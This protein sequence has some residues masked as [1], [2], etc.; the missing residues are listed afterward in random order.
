MFQRFMLMLLFKQII[1][2]EPLRH[3]LKIICKFC[4]MIFDTNKIALPYK[5]VDFTL[6]ILSLL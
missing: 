1:L 2:H 5:R 3:L 6:T 4:V